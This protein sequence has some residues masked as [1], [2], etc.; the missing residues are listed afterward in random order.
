MRARMQDRPLT[1][2]LVRERAELAGRRQVVSMTADGVVSTTYSGVVTRAEQLAASFDAH[3][4]APGARVATFCWNTA[5]HLA[6][7]LAVPCSGRVLHTV[8]VRLHPD[9]IAY[10]VEDAGDE[11]VVVDADLLPVLASVDLP[12]CVRLVVVEEPGNRLPDGAPS[13]VGSAEVVTMRDFL[14]RDAA[15]YRWP[16]LAEDEAAGLCY[17]SGTTG[18]PKGVVYSHRSTY[19]HALTLTTVDAFAIGAH[20][21]CMPVVPMFHA[22]AWG[23]PYASII[24]G[25][26][27]ALPGRYN[28]PESLAT[29]FSRAEVTFAAAVPT[30]WTALAAALRDGTVDAEVL[31]TVQ[32]MV[33]GGSAVSAALLAAFDAWGAPLLHAWGM[34]ECSPVGLVA[35]PAPGM[36]A[37]QAAVARLEQGRPLPGLTFRIRG[38]DGR[39]QPHDGQAMGE[40]EVSGPW[41]VSG[42]HRAATAHEETVPDDRFV[43]DVQGSWL[44]T[45]DIA[46]IDAWGSVR[47]VDRSKDLVKSG[48]EWISTVDLENAIASQSGVVEAAVVAVPDERWGERPHAVVVRS[49]GALT[50]E[51][52]RSA[53]VEKVARWQVPDVVSFV[54][55]LPRTSVG[56]IDKVR[57][58]ARL[59]ARAPDV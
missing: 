25:A 31:A 53:L 14:V 26:G 7:Y 30:V 49:D 2:A 48:G 54:D 59:A 22:N 33:V 51:D 38:E 45:G 43:E 8:N 55:D 12:A 13:R 32:R 56:K 9:E 11:V 40:L 39:P 3:G 52:V 17:T 10:I 18:R 42:Y 41:V 23:V 5:E 27:L 57:I 28:D 44:R 37:E 47:L 29:L 6:L 58:R 50:A 4:V 15:P 20:D 35:R 36:S 19:L 16:S 21:V 1:L 46:V 24:A 34:T